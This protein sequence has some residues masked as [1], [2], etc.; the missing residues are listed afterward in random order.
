MCAVIRQRAPPGPGRVWAPACRCRA[1]HRRAPRT[2]GSPAGT[3]TLL[4]TFTVAL[5]T[6]SWSQACARGS[7]C[8]KRNFTARFHGWAPALTRRVLVLLELPR[9]A[10]RERGQAAALTGSEV[11]PLS[12]DVTG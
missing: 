3:H 6:S 5:C 10:G 8:I 12:A 7:P 9:W 1:G 11:P 4:S 2:P